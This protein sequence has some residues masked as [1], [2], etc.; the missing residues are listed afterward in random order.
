MTGMKA[1]MIIFS[2]MCVLTALF[3]AGG[4]IAYFY[5]GAQD[6]SADASGGGPVGLVYV[7][8]MLASGVVGVSAAMLLI[9]KRKLNNSI[10]ET[11]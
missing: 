1:A 2:V 9:R 3:S 11:H 7:F 5:Y 4:F 8:A 6:M 10:N